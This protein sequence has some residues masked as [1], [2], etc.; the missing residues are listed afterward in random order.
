MK[1]SQITI[2]SI[3]IDKRQERPLGDIDGLIAS[4]GDVGLLHPIVIGSNGQLKV[5]YRRLEAF[6]RMGKERIPAHVTDELDDVLKALRAERDENVQRE[7]LPPT[8]M[9]ERA[10][11]L[12][13]AERD[14]ARVRQ[15]KAGK[16]FGRGK[17]ACGKLPQAIEE[18]SRDKVGAAFGVSGKTYEKAKRVVEAAEQEPEKFSDLPTIMDNKS[19]DAAHREMNKR[20]KSEPP[21]IPDDKYRVW[22]ADPPWQ[23]GNKG[24][25]DYGHAERHYPTM[26]IDELCAMGEEIKSKCE[27]SAVLFLWATSPLLE[28]SFKVINAWGFKYKTSFVWDKIKHNFGHYNSVRHEF[29]LICTRG[30]CVPDV[31]K[32]FDSVQSIPRSGKHSEKPEEFRN[33]IDTLYTHGKRIELFARGEAEN[34]ETWGNEP[35]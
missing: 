30:S 6:R 27:S 34:W 32:K 11:E 28:S 24:L 1:V 7:K 3:K 29:L 5:G 19:V 25:D 14:A 10:K 18:K 13:E 15:S 4:I 26:S 33:I 16:N 17:I 22:Y 9:V 21:P 2:D 12:E 31:D 35:S 8:V 20:R 23:Y